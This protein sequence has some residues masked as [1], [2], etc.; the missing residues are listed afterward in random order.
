MPNPVSIT[1]PELHPAQR[2]I[3][4]ESKRFNA[5]CAGRRFGKNTLALDRVVLT[6]LA[7]KPAAWFAPSYKL[8]S[9]VWRELQSRLRPLTQDSSEQ[10]RRL[11]LRGGGSIEMWS[12]DSPDA[13]RGRAFALIAVDEAALVADLLRVW[14][15]TL[16]PML[17]DHQGGAWFLSTPKGVANDFH[18]LYRYGQD[19]MKPDWA[20]WTMPTGEN[21]YIAPEEIE[22]ARQE[23]P[24]LAFAQEFLAQFVTWTGQV[25]RRIL[26]AVCEPPPGP[27]LIIGVDWGRSNDFTVFTA[28]HESGCVQEIDR[29]RGVDYPLQLD[30]LR[31]F[32]E[33]HGKPYIV[34]EDNSMGSVLVSQLR[35]DNLPA[36]P[37]AT[38]HAS[39]TMI[40]ETLALAFEQGAI[41]IPDDP[42]L[43]GE[44]QAYQSRDSSGY[45]KYGAPAGLH[46]DTV[47]S[48]AIGYGAL[49]AKK[50]YHAP[51]RDLYLSLDP[52]DPPGALVEY[53][54]R[55]VI[56]R[57]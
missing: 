30:R 21:P 20:S 6:A 56:S 54:Q 28:L 22:S 11:V 29:F 52:R 50:R 27:A 18:A 32:W 19:V 24:E 16:R 41:G 7:G 2:K 4:E 9:P 3:V 48:L 47:M 15:E 53:P 5:V 10:E 45:V 14:S 34:A 42:T 39:K 26:D 43:I 46:D 49:D 44:L 17:A 8:L 1:L 38:T 25:F 23:L 12:L 37:F 36:F 13:A 40:I 51:P 55:V 35:H 33:K 31:A 57:Y